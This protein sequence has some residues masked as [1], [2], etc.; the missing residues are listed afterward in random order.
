MIGKSLKYRLML[1]VSLAAAAVRNDDTKVSRRDARSC[2]R[3][4]AGVEGKSAVG[5][6]G[7][8]LSGSGRAL[9]VV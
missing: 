9:G 2:D 1:F 3:V 5:C 4:A 7:K 6:G 8:V